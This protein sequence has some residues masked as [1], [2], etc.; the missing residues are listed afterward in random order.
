MTGS[1]IAIPR[2]TLL[3]CVLLCGGSGWLFA[4]KVI[5]LKWSALS[6]VIAGHN[7]ELALPDGNVL[8]GKVLEV[9]PNALV[10]DVVKSSME[11][12]FPKGKNEIPR[13][14]V[15]VLKLIS[16]NAGKGAAIGVLVGIP[17][18]IANG[19]LQGVG[20]GIGTG[21]FCVGVGGLIGWASHHTTIIKILPD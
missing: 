4:A 16:S 5:E 14:Q 9:L 11:K 20:N 19:G 13:A 8:K 12:A 18:G 21:V 6:P 1:W 17:L 10:L 7:V 3:I 15:V 2:K